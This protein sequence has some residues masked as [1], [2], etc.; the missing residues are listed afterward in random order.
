[1]K[2]IKTIKLSI[3]ITT[4]GLSLLFSTANAGKLYK[5]VDAKG[6]I[7]Y[8]DNPPPK[9]SKILSEK[10]VKSSSSIRSEE[11]TSQNKSLPKVTIYTMN[12]CIDCDEFITFMRKNQVPHIARPLESDRD[13]QSYILSKVGAIKAP[14]MII[15]NNVIQNKTID[16][17]QAALIEAGYDIQ[18]DDAVKPAKTIAESES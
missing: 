11:Q 13:A 7:S 8:Q 16:E 5:W 15:G 12:N 2:T 14:T 4:I 3:A 9:G 17:F 6:K 18:T 10:E 1:M